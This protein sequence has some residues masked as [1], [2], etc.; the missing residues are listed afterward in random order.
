MGLVALQ[1]LA[2]AHREVASLLNGSAGHDI[3][4]ENAAIIVALREDVVRVVRPGIDF[5]LV[6]RAEGSTHRFWLE[7]MIQHVV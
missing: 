2:G 1:K 7:H 5:D 6:V 3:G 4:H